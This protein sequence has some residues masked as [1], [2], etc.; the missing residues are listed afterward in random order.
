MGASEELVEK[1]SGVRMSTVRTLQRL[2]QG[3][4][5]ADMNAHIFLSSGEQDQEERSTGS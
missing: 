4:H 1:L 2:F 5:R 3:D